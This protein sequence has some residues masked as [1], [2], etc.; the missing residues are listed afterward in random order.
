[1]I[2][3]K[4]QQTNFNNITCCH[5]PPTLLSSVYYNYLIK[6]KVY[7]FVDFLTRLPLGSVRLDRRVILT[8]CFFSSQLSTCFSLVVRSWAAM[9][10]EKV[11]SFTCTGAVERRPPAP[12]YM[13]GYLWIQTFF[14]KR[15]A[16]YYCPE[17]DHMLK[18]IEIKQ[19][20]RKHLTR[21]QPEIS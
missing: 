6:L 13:C 9:P 8:W 2:C 3:C 12:L 10:D 20:Q 19:G 15:S 1:M 7:M 14:T 11:S 4:S 21:S 18:G 16:A 5:T 17:N